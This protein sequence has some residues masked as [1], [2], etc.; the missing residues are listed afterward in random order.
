MRQSHLDVHELQVS[1]WTG[2]QGPWLL[3]FTGITMAGKHRASRFVDLAR[4]REWTVLLFDGYSSR[5]ESDGTVFVSYSGVEGESLPA[6]MAR[7]S[8]VPAP[9]PRS[10]NKAIR[11]LGSLCRP[12]WGWRILRSTLRGMRKMPPPIAIAFCDESATPL[13]WH[14]ARLWVEAPVVTHPSEL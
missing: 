12:F 13:A 8:P 2:I 4:E 5:D 6:H 1:G 11:R 14:A 10:L 7:H 3:V 9:I